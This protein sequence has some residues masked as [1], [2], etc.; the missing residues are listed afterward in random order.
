MKIYKYLDNIAFINH[1]KII[2]QDSKKKL[3]EDLGSRYFDIE[4]DDKDMISQN[5]LA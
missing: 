4:F 3:L 2:K 5:Y 1:G